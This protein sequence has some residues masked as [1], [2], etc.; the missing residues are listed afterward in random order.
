MATKRWTVRQTTKGKI[1]AEWNGQRVKLIPEPTGYPLEFSPSN[2]GTLTTGLLTAKLETPE[3]IPTPIPIPIPIP[4]PNPTPPPPPPDPA[5]QPAPPLTVPLRAVG[6]AAGVRIGRTDGILLPRGLVND[7]RTVSLWSGT[8]RVPA[9]CYAIARWP[10]E[11]LKSVGVSAILTSDQ[12]YELGLNGS[13]VDQLPASSKTLPWQVHAT[14]KGTPLG[15]PVSYPSPEAEA[16]PLRCTVTHR[17]RL[18]DAQHLPHRTG[19]ILRHTAYQGWAGVRAELTLHDTQQEQVGQH[20]KNPLELSRL[21][22]HLPWKATSATFGTETQPVTVALSSDPVS[23][24]QRGELRFKTVP[25][26]TSVQGVLEG[27]DLS[28]TGVASGTKAPGW[29]WLDGPDGPLGIALQD[30]WQ[31]FPFA[32]TVTRDGVTIELHPQRSTDEPQPQSP[33]YFTRLRTLALY[34]Q[35]MT[36]RLL[37]GPGMSLAEFQGVQAAFQADAH[38][39]A[40]PAWMCDSAACGPTA[41]AGPQSVGYDR[42]LLEGVYERSF[43]QKEATGGIALPYGWQD[44]GD[45]FRP[46]Y[47]VWDTP[48]GKLAAPMVYQDCHVGGTNPAQQ[49]IR[50]GDPRW[51]HLARIASQRH[52]NNGHSWVSRIG[53]W[54]GGGTVTPPGELLAIKHDNFAQHWSRNVH[55]G[56][57]H[58]SG[59]AEWYLLTGD[60][61]ARETLHR[62]G[63]WYVPMVD[64]LFPSDGSQATWTD[65]ER[66]FAWPQHVVT[67]VY[68]ATGQRTYHE[69]GVKEVLSCVKWWQTVKD[70]TRGYK[71]VGTNPDGTPKFEPIVVG[72]FDWTLGLGCWSPKKSD[73]D[74]AGWN[75]PSPWYSGALAGN[76]IRVLEDDVDF[77]LLDRDLVT[78]MVCQCMNAVVQFGYSTTLKAFCYSEAAALTHQLPISASHIYFPLAWARRELHSRPHPEWFTTAPLWDDILTRFDTWAA[79]DAAPGWTAEFGFYGYEMVWPA[80]YWRLRA[81]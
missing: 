53:H 36:W 68:R 66:D 26:G 17:G 48:Q 70:H 24:Y 23:L 40:S 30:G 79:T 72:R 80:D 38:L 10:D 20:P 4:I 77:G 69:L 61:L 47:E 60:P 14:S 28:Y 51:R 15:L 33:P 57:E 3:P 21:A 65:A 31:Q 34:G 37:V 78:E 1:I 76:I 74:P 18:T 64:P 46:G 67:Q 75:G 62:R 19:F 58:I 2:V 59:V 11:S 43:A 25:N 32:L 7:P 6:I 73:N 8:T 63:D 16:D 44:Y 39:E 35:A 41:A 13:P 56:H 45:R 5:P 12:P 71:Q 9:G 54:F 55:T 52:M 42:M 22:L 27:F 81:A 49:Y 50:T 29:V